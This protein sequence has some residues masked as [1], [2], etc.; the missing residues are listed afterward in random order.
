MGLNKYKNLLNKP[1]KLDF[2][3]LQDISLICSNTVK[4]LNNYLFKELLL[5]TIDNTPPTWKWDYRK[6]KQ[7]FKKY[8]SIFYAVRINGDKIDDACKDAYRQFRKAMEV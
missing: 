3:T 4:V 7:M 5:R 2:D 6:D 8:F 1:I